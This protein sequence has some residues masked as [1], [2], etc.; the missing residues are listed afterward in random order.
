MREW[1][2]SSTHMFFISV[3]DGSERSAPSFM[4]FPLPPLKRAFCIHWRG[5]FCKAESIQMLWRIIST[6]LQIKS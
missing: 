3:L 5:G 4:L 2:Y 6:P 1:R